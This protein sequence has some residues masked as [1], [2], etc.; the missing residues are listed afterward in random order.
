MTDKPTPNTTCI[1]CGSDYP[2][3]RAA[4]GYNTCLDCGDFAAR[5][6]RM[7]WTIVPLP[8]QGY[9]RV[10]RVEELKGLNQKPK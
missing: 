4:L 2:P 8:K 6:E 7:S 10:T 5:T 3:Q 1:A 9:T